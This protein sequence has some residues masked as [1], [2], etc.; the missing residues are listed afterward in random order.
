MGKRRGVG[1]PQDNSRPATR[2]QR[3]TRYRLQCERGAGRSAYRETGRNIDEVTARSFQAP[4]V[5]A[6]A[7][8]PRCKPKAAFLLRTATAIAMNRSRAMDRGRMRRRGTGAAGY[9]N[10]RR[11]AEASRCQPALRRILRAVGGLHEE[12]RRVM[13]LKNSVWRQSSRFADSLG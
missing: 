1:M 5:T 9:R 13:I 11:L 4:E 3:V 7:A 8:S 10:F 6:G 2:S 12:C